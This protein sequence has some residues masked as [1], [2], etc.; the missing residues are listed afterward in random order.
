MTIVS[1]IR[2]RIIKESEEKYRKFSTS[3][4][5]GVT[6][7]A[8]VRIPVLRKIARDIAKSD[9]QTFLD[10][11]NCIY[12]EE[13]MLKGIV[14]GLVKEPPEKILHLI[15]AFIPE[16]NNWAVCDTFCC[17]LKFI[18]E[19]QPLVWDFLQ[20]YLYSA[21]EFEIRSAVVILLNF[22]IDEEYLGRVLNTL[23]KIKTDDYYA[24]MAIAW[25]ISIC[26]IKFEKETLEFLQS[27]NLDKFTFNKT[28][29][30]I[31][32]SYRI[33]K[34]TKQKLKLLKK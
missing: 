31:I 9:W 17:G 33:P 3:L 24:Q 19:N 1:E 12:M 7:V 2:E 13:T 20:Q 22:Y 6:N 21:K 28:I 29:Q 27:C 11:T 32:E 25:A 14:I 4:L 5:P 26:Y 10:N 30:K 18:Q 23:N 15:Q 8:G 16:I 34:E